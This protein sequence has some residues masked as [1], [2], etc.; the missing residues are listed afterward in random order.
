MEKLEIQESQIRQLF[1][2]VVWTHK[3]QEKEA[4]RLRAKYKF[5]DTI[6]IILSALTSSGIFSTIFIDEF[7][8]KIVTAVMSTITLFIN[9]YCKTYDL[10]TEAKEHKESA[11]ALFTLREKIISTLSDIKCCNLTFDEVIN[12]KNSLYNEY[13]DICKN[14]KDAS[15]KAVKMASKALNKSK[16]NQY[17]DEEIDSF[18]PSA[19]RKNRKE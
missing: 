15:P 3:I 10:K 9:I 8:L 2:S 7:C 16:D 13:F 1:G 5:I 6:K 18:L 4:D 11:L 17:S 19:L 12:I 14:T